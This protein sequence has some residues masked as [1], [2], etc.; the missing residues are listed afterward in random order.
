MMAV[1]LFYLGCYIYLYI[2]NGVG[3]LVLYRMQDI[4][5]QHEQYIV[6]YTDNF[7]TTSMFNAFS[8]RGGPV[9]AVDLFGKLYLPLH[10]IWS[11]WDWSFI[12]CKIYVRGI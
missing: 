8:I 7:V 5:R 10:N 12:V 1:D 3:G 4:Y 2:I 6:W 9:T 11:R